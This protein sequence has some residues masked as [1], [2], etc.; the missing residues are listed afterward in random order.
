L[1]PSIVQQI[2]FLIPNNILS[3]P[4]ETN[5]IVLRTM[6]KTTA[7]AT[8]AKTIAT[9]N[10]DQAPIIDQATSFELFP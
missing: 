1:H 7:N 6:K 4:L 10:E 5:G 3:I 8:T 2:G 9:I